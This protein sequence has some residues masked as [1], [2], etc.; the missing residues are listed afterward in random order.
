M[1][2]AFSAHRSGS[3]T[4]N[5]ANFDADVGVSRKAVG[6]YPPNNWGFHDMHGNAWEW[7]GTYYPLHYDGSYTVDPIGPETGSLVYI[8]GG[9]YNS[10]DKF[11]VASPRRSHDYAN[12][13]NVYGFRVSLQQN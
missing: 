5:D 12:L 7:T 11:I 2:S 4:K 13:N 10:Y 3:I 1:R 6:S 9:N 8:R